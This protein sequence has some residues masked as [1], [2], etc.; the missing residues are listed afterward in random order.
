M[1]CGVCVCVSVC[2]CVCVGVYA[3]WC[4]YMCWVCEAGAITSQHAAGLT[5]EVYSGRKEEMHSLPVVEMEG[6]GRGPIR[7]C[8]TRT[9]GTV[10]ICRLLAASDAVSCSH[11]APQAADFGLL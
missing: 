3:L 8:R 4:L 5:W 9:G 6:R 7:E 1:H 11:Q 10:G 2:V